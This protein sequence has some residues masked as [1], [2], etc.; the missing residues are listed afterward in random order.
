MSTSVSAPPSLA[1]RIAVGA[2]SLFALLGA[3]HAVPVVFDTPPFQGSAA[4]P[5]DGIRTIFGGNERFLPA[6]DVSQDSFVFD[7][8]AFGLPPTLSFASS[9]A[10]ALSPLGA[11]VIVLQDI[12]NDA[13]PATPFNAGTA[14]NLIAAAVTEDVAGFFIYSNSGLGVNRLVFSTNLN[15]NTADLAILARILSPSGVDAQ[16]ALPSFTAD[17]FGVQGVPEPGTAALLAAGMF[18]MAWRRRQATAG[19]PG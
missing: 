17:N 19:R 16:S 13:N 3:A 4:D 5:N 8:G 14:A 15:S 10:A 9:T 18:A 12:D 6:F 2:L 11:K 7:A 1:R